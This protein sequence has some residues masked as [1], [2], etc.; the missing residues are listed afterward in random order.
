MDSAWGAVNEILYSPAFKK[1]REKFFRNWD[2]L[3]QQEVFLQARFLAKTT[4]SFGSTSRSP[5]LASFQHN[6]RYLSV[7]D[8]KNGT[9]GYELNTV[10]NSTNCSL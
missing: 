9:L 5:I 6:N 10:L 4:I 8:P 2:G 7:R 3:K 1:Y